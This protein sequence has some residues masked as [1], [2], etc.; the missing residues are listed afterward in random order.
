MIE[1]VFVFAFVSA[2]FELVVLMKIRPR[3][4]LRILGSK[5]WVLL[6]HAM[7]FLINIVVHYGTVT[8]S[9]TAITAALASFATIPLATWIS[10]SIANGM[11]RPGYLKYNV[12]ELR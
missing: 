5:R 4:R 6:I 10:G 1:T 7:T 2:L 8:G 11:Y 9:L 3:T 12:L